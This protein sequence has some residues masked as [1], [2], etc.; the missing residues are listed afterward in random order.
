MR[1]SPSLYL[2]ALNQGK[3]VIVN[4]VHLRSGLEGTQNDTEATKQGCKFFQLQGLE[5]QQGKEAVFLCMSKFSLIYHLLYFLYL[6]KDYFWIAFSCSSWRAHRVFLLIFLFV[7]L[8]W[9]IQSKCWHFHC[10]VVVLVCTALESAVILVS[11][12]C[13]SFHGSP[14]ASRN[15]NKNV[16]F[17]PFTL[18]GVEV[19]FG[20]LS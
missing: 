12:A 5:K 4:D 16:S 1:C 7:C 6:C 3:Q 19:A 11:S 10:F 17:L 14:F 9:V 20:S 2:L 15:M 18:K 8:F 13:M